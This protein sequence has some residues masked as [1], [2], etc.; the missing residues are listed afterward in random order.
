MLTFNSCI[1]PKDVDKFFEKFIYFI[2]KSKGGC[3]WKNLSIT[4]LNTWS[5]EIDEA[6]RNTEATTA[7][8]SET[9]YLRRPG[10][11]GAS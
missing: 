6:Y 7:F 4:F 9:Q 10:Y 5:L 2:T 8:G 11:D 1:N 3:Q